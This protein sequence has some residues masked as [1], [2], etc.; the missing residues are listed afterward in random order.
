MVT[1]LYAL[2]PALTSNQKF[3]P[4]SANDAAPESAPDG[5]VAVGQLPLDRREAEALTVFVEAGLV[6]AA[7]AGR[8]RA[9]R[10]PWGAFRAVG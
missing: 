5:S 9:R 8:V 3:A 1:A 6:S 2:E 7:E 4:E 10:E